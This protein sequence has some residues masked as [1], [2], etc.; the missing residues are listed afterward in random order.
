MSNLNSR[1]VMDGWSFFKI[2]PSFSRDYHHPEKFSR[3][4]ERTSQEVLGHANNPD[5][6]LVQAK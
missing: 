5:C 2:I 4:L 1:F 3:P 6:E